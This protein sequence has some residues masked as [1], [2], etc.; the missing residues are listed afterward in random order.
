MNYYPV[1]L[2]LKNR[3]VLLV[4]GGKIGLQKL[5]NLL[6]GE[7]SVHLVAPEVLPGIRRLARD[8]KIKWSARSYKTTDMRGAALAIAA[9]DDSRLQKRIAADA[10]ARGV[11]VNIVDVPALCGFIAPAIVRRGKIQVAISTGG[12]A[13]ALAKHLRGKMEAVLGPEHAEFAAL[14][15]KWRPA[16]LKMPR[17]ARARFWKRAVTDDFM[18]DIRTHGIARAERRLKGW[19]HAA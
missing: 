16:I 15:E 14:V 1:Y 13:P 11:W 19:I 2:N 7:A 3:R 12:A 6:R 9:T 17:K 10:R 8:G 4:G 18:S 5:T